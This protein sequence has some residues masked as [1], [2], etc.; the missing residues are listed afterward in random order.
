VAITGKIA[1]PIGWAGRSK[2]QPQ[3]SQ[4]DLQSIIDELR[5]IN[6][7]LRSLYF[8]LIKHDRSGHG[9]RRL[10]C[11]IITVEGYFL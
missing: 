6:I 8:K 10:H 3:I 7:V 9:D 1:I 4:G 11:R 5:M 2:T